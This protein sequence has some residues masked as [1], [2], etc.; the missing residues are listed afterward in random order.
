VERRW[1]PIE[2]ARVTDQN[3]LARLL[4]CERALGEE[5]RAPRRVAG[6]DPEVLH[7]LAELHLEHAELLRERLAALGPPE[8]LNSLPELDDSWITRRDRAGLAQSERWAI[9]TY[10]D[11]LGDFDRATEV[12]VRE[13]I[14]PHLYGALAALDPSF[15]PDRDGIP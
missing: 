14:L 10:H 13:V 4:R 5:F 8:H 7:A 1:E 12:L 15:Q 3:E 2:A 6:V 9:A 11:H